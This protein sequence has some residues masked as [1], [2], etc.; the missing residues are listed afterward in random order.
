MPVYEKRTKR[1]MKQAIFK[2]LAREKTTRLYS[3]RFPV[4]GTTKQNGLR[5]KSAVNATNVANRPNQETIFVNGPVVAN[6]SY[7]VSYVYK[8]HSSSKETLPRVKML[9]RD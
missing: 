4:K 8:P 6:D 2:V 3:C 7:F 9:F 5:S 1:V